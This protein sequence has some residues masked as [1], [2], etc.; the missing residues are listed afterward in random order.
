MLAFMSFVDGVFMVVS[1]S[2]VIGRW[3]LVV[4]RYR[5]ELIGGSPVL[6]I[7]KVV[8]DV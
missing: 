4:G 5:K 1:W 2:L 7:I 3:S 6:Y 8:T